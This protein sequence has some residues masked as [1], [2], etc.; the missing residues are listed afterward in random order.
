LEKV[1]KASDP[2]RRKGV[3]IQ[4]PEKT[5]TSVIVHTKDEAFARQLEAELNADI[6]WND[7]IDQVK[8]RERHN[9]EVMRY[10]AL[11]RKPLTEAQSRKN[12][13][14]YLKNMACFKMN[15]F[16]GMTYSEI[17]PIFEKHY[18]SIQA[19][20]EKGEEE[21]TV[22]E[23]EVEEEGNKRQGKSLE[24]EIAKKHS[25]LV[26]KPPPGM[27]IAALWHQ[28]SPVLPQTRSLTSSGFSR[29]ITPLFENMLVPVA[30][31]VGEAQD[32]VSIP[33][34]PS[35]SKPHKKHK[36]KKQQQIAPKVPSHAPSL[37]HQLPSP[38]NDLIPNADKD[39]LTLQELVDLCIRL[40]TKVLDLESEDE[41]FARQL[42]AELNADINWNDVIDQVKR[43]ERHNNEVMRYQ[44]LK[45]KPLT[46]AQ[47]RKNM[48]I[49][50][51]NMACFKMNFFKGMT[52]SEIRP[53]F[54]K[55]YNS[56][57]AFLEKGEEEVTVKEKEVEE[58][59]NKRQGESLEQEIAKKHRVD[60]EAEELKRHL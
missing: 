36:S 49:Y 30:E 8:R 35:T 7:V 31:E 46:E 58:K 10:Q 2:R 41:A 42:E 38:S 55:H 20:L 26:L 24:Q 52:Y 54:E 45:R 28:Q 60:E 15:F 3:I 33:T 18:N 53:I 11:K 21:V 23:K 57:Q 47:S 32:D 29:V 59:G 5:T 16:K 44:A 22:K 12:M 37:E 14:I 51:K 19:F 6:N 25:A 13:M 48:M 17:R 40:S 27:N 50:L 9:N 43:R 34:E 1:P 4:D 56:I 39:S